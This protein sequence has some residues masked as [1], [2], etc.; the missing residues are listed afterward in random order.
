MN[1]FQKQRYLA[2][3]ITDITLIVV[4]FIAARILFPSHEKLLSTRNL[5]VISFI[6]VAWYF[7]A[8]VSFLYDH[9]ISRKLSAEFLILLKT[10]IYFSFIVSIAAFFVSKDPLYSKKFIIAFL[11]VLWLMLPLEKYLIRWFYAGFIFKKQVVKVL[12]VGAGELALRFYNKVIYTGEYG[13]K[14]AGF[15]DDV[16]NPVLN[17]E[18]L[19]SISKLEEVLNSQPDIQDVIIALPVTEAVKIQQASAIAEQYYKRVSIIP[20]Y[21]SY[22]Q[23]V[24]VSTLGAF[25]LV[26]LRRLPLDDVEMRFFKRVFDVILSICIFVFVFSWLFPIIILLI[27]L[28]TKGSVFFVQERWGLNSK[29]IRCL[30][31]RTM[32]GHSNE[33]DADGKYQQ[34]KKNDPR[35]TKIGRILRKTSLDELPQFFNVIRGEMSIV[36]PRPHP[37][38]LNIESKAHVSNYMMR[39]WVKPGITGWAQVNGFRGETK[40][41][42]QMQKRIDF[43]LW[44]IENWSFWLDIQIIFQTIINMLKGDRN[45]Y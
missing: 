27:K 11:G 4:A 30:K 19:G 25:P 35:I 18:Y 22:A 26:S 31:F 38:P 29:P 8:K 24:S 2:R 39:H 15:I 44:Y 16:P 45:A 40:E 32:L 34:A 7:S 10:L 3:F 5:Q 21:F 41:I 17:G 13:Y 23:S 37:I 14:L 6:L 36:G 12:I 28:T 1:S 20:D 9:F 42:R 43:D 33:V